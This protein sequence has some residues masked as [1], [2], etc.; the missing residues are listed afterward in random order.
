[1]RPL[2]HQFRVFGPRN[3]L[4]VDQDQETLIK[5]RGQRFKSYAE[6]FVPSLGFAAQHLANVRANGRSFLNNDLHMK[7]GLKHLIE[8]FYRSIGEGAAVPIPYRQIVLTARIMDAIFD[9]VSA[10]DMPAPAGGRLLDGRPQPTRTG[11]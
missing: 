5:L 11:S 3:G 10:R 2:L 6:K 4:V 8:A 9:Q 1:M 7:S